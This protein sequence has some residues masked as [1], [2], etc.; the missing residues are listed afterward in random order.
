MKFMLMMHAPK[1]DGD[2][3]VSQWKKE[4][5]EAHFDFMRR[6]SGELA[7]AGELVGAEGLASPG[8]ARI[9]RATATG[10]PR[11][12]PAQVAPL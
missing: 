9:V 5:L 6:F 1:G 2:W 11:P 3:N 7:A 4:D 10:T 12:P 8:E